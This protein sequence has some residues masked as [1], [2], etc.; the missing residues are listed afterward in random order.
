M[1]NAIKKGRKAVGFSQQQLAEQAGC[2]I[3]SVRLYERSFV[4]SDV[5]QPVYK[6]IVAALANA[7]EKN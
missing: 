3:A 2:S 7:K 5:E 4:P 6:R 1:T